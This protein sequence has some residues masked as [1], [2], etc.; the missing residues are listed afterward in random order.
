MLRQL[1][2]GQG[3]TGDAGPSTS[4]NPLA[5]LFSHML[6]TTK[7]NEYLHEVRT[8][9]P[10][11]SK[12]DQDKIRNRSHIHT[13]HL[14]PDASPEVLQQQLQ[15]FLRSLDVSDPASAANDLK[16]QEFL[17]G[18]PHQAA[19]HLDWTAEYQRGAQQQHGSSDY[20]RHPCHDKLDQQAY[21][22]AWHASA[23]TSDLAADLQQLPAP[24]SKLQWADAFH[25]PQQPGPASWAEDFARHNQQAAAAQQSNDSLPGQAWASE[26]QSQQQQAHPANQLWADQFLDGTDQVWVEQFRQQQQQS[27]L[28]EQQLSPEER[29]ALR[30]AHPD[31][32]LDDRTALSWVRQFNEEAAKPSVNVGQGSLSDLASEMRLVP[33]PENPFS[34]HPTPMQTGRKLQA[35]GRTQ[36][37]ALAFEIAGML[38]PSNAEAWMQLGSC[39]FQLEQFSAAI[40]P[41]QRASLLLTPDGVPHGGINL[42]DTLWLLVQACNGAGKK[43]E[44][45]RGME[46]LCQVKAEAAGGGVVQAVQ[47]AGTSLESRLQALSRALPGDASIYLLLGMLRNA[48]GNKEAAA[49]AY[50]AAVRISVDAPMLAELAT[51][52]RGLGKHA[53]AQRCCTAAVTAR[54]DYQRGWLELGRA[55]A[56]QGNFA[57]A[58][59]SYIQ[60]L[61]IKAE[62]PSIWDSLSMAFVAMGQF[63][64][65]DLADRHDLAGLTSKPLAF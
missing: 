34:H 38:V 2:A 17:T 63:P 65:A 1:V 56:A 4:S 52:L 30:G 44:A 8:T 13:R 61:E 29:R 25:Q 54:P 26:Y 15:T 58:C 41:L 5:G 23:Q 35:T 11:F 64:L 31:D 51:A 3:C 18:E 43:E 19:S 59:Q 9:I 28:V 24:Q 16:Y 32:P 45:V 37:A 46:R 7:H 47:S 36:D 60:A 39:R 57:E 42:Q 62:S 6:G 20:L 22:D 14:F 49:N 55:Q 50:A 27:H 33:E 12:I 21:K 53:E 40:P 10:T 48:K